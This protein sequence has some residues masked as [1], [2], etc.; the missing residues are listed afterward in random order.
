MESPRCKL[1][2]TRHWASRPCAGPASTPEPAMVQPAPPPVAIPLPE[3]IPLPKPRSTAW[4]EHSDIV[5]I[6]RARVSPDT[7]LL[8]QAADEI[9]RLRVLAAKAIQR[10]AYQRDL[11]RRRRA[12]RRVHG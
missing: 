4:P 9:E 11:M 3:H 8:N 5:P 12:E 1:C 7:D 10:N 6:L 2:G